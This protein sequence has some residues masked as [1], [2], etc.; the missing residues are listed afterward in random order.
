MKKCQDVHVA[1][2]VEIM[3]FIIGHYVIVCKCVSFALRLV[4]LVIIKWLLYNFW[5][6]SC[7]NK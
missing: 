2:L 3:L 1:S 6:Y 5:S 4:M 7:V